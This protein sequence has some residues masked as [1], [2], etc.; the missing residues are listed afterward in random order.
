MPIPAWLFALVLAATAPFVVR[1]F[2]TEVDRR[3]RE[4]TKR[5]LASRRSNDEAV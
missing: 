1:A 4:R 5:V 3:A 2:A